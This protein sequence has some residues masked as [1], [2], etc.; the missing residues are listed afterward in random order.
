MIP[1]C[2]ED[3]WL[4]ICKWDN[5]YYQELYL[6]FSLR[7]APFIFNLFRE[8]LQWIL[9]NKYSYVIKRYLDDFLF[10]LSPIVHTSKVEQ[11]GA[12]FKTICSTLGFTET[13]DKSTNYTHINYLGLILD[14]VKME[15]QLL[16]DKK[17]RALES[18]QNVLRHSTITQKQ[19]QK[20]LSLL[21]L[22]IKVFPL[23][24]PFLQ[25]IW[26][27]FKKEHSERQKL[28]NSARQD[29]TWWVAFLLI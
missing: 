28:T 9:H 29:L 1:V 27:M 4:L 19:L 24:R 11:A 25:C 6:P 17:N 20:L 2:T 12:Q 21:E 22:C 10:I 5:K 14:T 3:Q 8:V 15:A 7:T 16:E 23:G 26:N 13:E 18:I